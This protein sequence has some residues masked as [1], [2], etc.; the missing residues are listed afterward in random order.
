MQNHKYGTRDGSR[1]KLSTQSMLSFM[2][3]K[4]LYVNNTRKN[5]LSCLFY[6]KTNT[7]I[8]KFEV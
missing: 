8:A 4:P 2:N 5:L 6:I 3:S 7:S 1:L